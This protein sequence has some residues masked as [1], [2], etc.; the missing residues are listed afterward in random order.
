MVQNNSNQ[1]CK[2]PMAALNK[3]LNVTPLSKEKMMINIS[4][5]FGDD[6]PGQ[7]KSIE[8]KFNKQIPLT[9][10]LFSDGSKEFIESGILQS[11]K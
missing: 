8:Y 11:K 1:S 3:G 4:K 7:K 5:I 9:T 2:F 10:K 6:S